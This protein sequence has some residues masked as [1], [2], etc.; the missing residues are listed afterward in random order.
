VVASWFRRNTGLAFGIT[1]SGTSV[2]GVLI[3]PIAAQVIQRYGW[4]MGY[5]ALAAIILLVALPLVIW[6]LRENPA[7][8]KAKGAPTTSM[9]GQTLGETFKDSRFW[10]LMLSLGLAA[11]PMG[12]YLVHLQPLLR[13]QHFSLPEAAGYGSLFALAIGIGRVGGGFLIDKLWDFGVATALI[14]LAALGCFTVTSFGPQDARWAITAAIVAIGLSYGAEVNFGAYFA[15]KLFGLRSYSKIFGFKSLVVGGGVAL[16]GMMVS[17]LFDLTGSYKLLGPVTGI[18]FLLAA[19]TMLLIGLKHE[20]T[21]A[22][23]Q[24]V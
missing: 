3:V 10:F 23:A 14:A 20:R 6:L 8:V 24:P 13:T 5:L 2:G 22:A 7:A 4:R 9:D 12:A 18:L 15:L 16:G 1:L 21:Q 19:V 11:L 17:A